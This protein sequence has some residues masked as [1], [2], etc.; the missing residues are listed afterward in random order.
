MFY[1]KWFESGF[2][3]GW[4]KA[5]EFTLGPFRIENTI[6]DIICMVWGQLLEYLLNIVQGRDFPVTI[7]GVFLI[8]FSR[9]PPKSPKLYI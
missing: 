8:V 6:K 5:A 4:P 3:A 1:P 7:F 9:G 2:P